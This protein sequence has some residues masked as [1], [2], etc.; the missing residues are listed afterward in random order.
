MT[1]HVKTLLI[2]SMLLASLAAG[3][4]R[5]DEGSEPADSVA[6]DDAL[7]Q[8][9]APSQPARSPDG[10]EHLVPDL[11]INPYRMEQGP[12]Q[13]EH[14]LAFSPGYGNLGSEKLF[15]FRFAYNPNSWLGYEASI[16]HNPG[17]SVHAVLHTLNAIVRHPWPGRFQPYLSG[18]YGMVM[19]FPGKSVNA[20][21]V[22]KNALMAGGGLEF[23]IRSD[24][25]VRGDAQYATVFGRERAREGVVTFD[26]L[27]Y[28]FGL[29]FY[30]T[31]RP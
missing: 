13:F 2:G 6:A 23:Y 10:L 9:V 8:W 15:A 16:G 7:T 11:A 19:V 25:A 17:Q 5:G 14:R 21:P 18:G 24:L 30:R 27:Q 3:P 12:R 28:T 1:R 4:A 31:I 29:A 20:D 22:T 26:Y